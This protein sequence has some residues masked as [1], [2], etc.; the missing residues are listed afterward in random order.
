MRTSIYVIGFVFVATL[1]SIPGYSQDALEPVFPT[2]GN[3]ILISCHG[4]NLRVT[5][6]LRVTGPFNPP[7]FTENL[8]YE[9][10]HAHPGVQTVEGVITQSG[11]SLNGTRVDKQFFIDEGSLRDESAV[12][13]ERPGTNWHVYHESL[14]FLRGQRSW[15]HLREDANPRTGFAGSYFLDCTFTFSR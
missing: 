8:R 5:A 15:V 10:R 2:T 7:V 12:N 4:Q 3:R 9:R 11:V 14:F 13:S 6:D 1:L